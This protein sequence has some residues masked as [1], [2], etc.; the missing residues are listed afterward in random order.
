M[1]DIHKN[2]VIHEVD[3]GYNVE[4]EIEKCL[5]TKISEQTIED[6]SDILE[7]VSNRSGNK[8]AI[9]KIHMDKK[10]EE[11]S[12]IIIEKGQIHKDL[13]SEIT[14]LNTI[15]AVGKLRGFALKNYNKK[16]VKKSKDVYEFQD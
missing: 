10:L 16:F 4:E 1:E 3:L 13:I 12:K 14:G 7:A 5:K 9:E 15:S 2:L 11:V 6:I 8:K